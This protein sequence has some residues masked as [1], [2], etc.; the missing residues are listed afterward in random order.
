MITAKSKN[1]PFMISDDLRRGQEALLSTIETCETDPEPEPGQVD[2]G[3][4]ES[5][6]ILLFR[7][8]NYVVHIGFVSILMANIFS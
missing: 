6:Y 7:C 3:R 2:Q 8:K 1:I 4:Q 5:H